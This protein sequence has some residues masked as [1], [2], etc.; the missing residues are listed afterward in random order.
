[1]R[2]PENR[3]RWWPFSR[4]PPLGRKY[5]IQPFPVP[6][7][8]ISERCAIANTQTLDKTYHV[9]VN[10]LVE[11]GQTLYDSELATELGCSIKEG[12]QKFHVT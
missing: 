11:T 8:V 2:R 7:L 9:I 12:R 6:E 10:R 1:M 3:G 4:K 5:I